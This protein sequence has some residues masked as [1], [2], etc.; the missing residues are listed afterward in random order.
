MGQLQQAHAELTSALPA[1]VSVTVILSLLGKFFWKW[2]Y[3]NRNDTILKKKI[4]VFNV[5]IK[6]KDLHHLFVAL[7]GTPP[8]D[9]IAPNP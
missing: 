3:L 6:V 2:Y 9:L 7:F 5:T 1:G 4:V 8:A